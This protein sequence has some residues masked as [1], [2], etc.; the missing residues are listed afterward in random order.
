MWIRLAAGDDLGVDGGTDSV[1]LSCRRR[2]LAVEFGDVVCEDVAVVGVE[3]ADFTRHLGLC[4]ESGRP[5][6]SF[7][8]QVLLLVEKLGDGGD[9]DRVGGNTVGDGSDDVGRAVRSKLGVGESS[10]LGLAS[11]ELSLALNNRT[12]I[13]N[14]RSVAE[15]LEEGS[16]A[17]GEAERIEEISTEVVNGGDGILESRG[18]RAASDGNIE[19]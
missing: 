3:D 12:R 7:E 8:C 15:R 19:C 13:F 14:G 10:L 2:T 18:G 9:A 1:T 5:G 16:A 4:C 6:A 11:V 17:R